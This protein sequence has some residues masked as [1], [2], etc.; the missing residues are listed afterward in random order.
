MSASARFHRP[1]KYAFPAVISLFFLLAIAF[2]GIVRAQPITEGFDGFV[3]PDWTVPAGWTFSGI[4]AWDNYTTPDDF[5]L[6]SPSIKLDKDGNYIR[7]APLVRPDE[8]TFWVKGQGDQVSSA[9]LVEEYCA[10]WS[11]VTQ[12]SPIPTTGT[13]LGP[14]SLQ[15]LAIEV[16]FTYEKFADEGDLAF[17]DV[18][19]TL[20]DPT[21]TPSPTPPPT[22]TPTPTATSTPIPPPTATPPPLTNFY[23]PSFELDPELI[24]WSKVGTASRINRSDEVAYDGD[25]SLVFEE[26]TH[27]NYAARGIETDEDYLVPVIPGKRYNFSGWFYVEENGPGDDIDNVQLLF[28]VIWLN[29]AGDEVST[30]T[31]QG[32]TLEEFDTWTERAKTLIAPPDATQVRI[33]VACR[34]ATTD[35]QNDVYI[36]QF[37]LFIPPATP[38]PTATPVGYKTPSPTPVPQSGPIRGRVYDRVTGEGV[39]GV[40]VLAFFID[41]GLRTSGDVTD[42]SG[43]YSI[44]GIDGAPL[45][46]GHYQVWAQGSQGWGIRSYHDQWYNQK[47]SRPQADVV[48]SNSLGIDFPLY[49]VGEFPMVRVESGDY[50]GDGASDIAVF[51]PTSGL[52]AVRGVTRAYFGSGG[53]IPVSGDYTGDGTSDIA[54]FR[55]ASGL[56]AVRGVTRAYFGTAGDIP[57]PGDY[58]GDGSTDIAVFRSATGLW[59]VKDVS[60]FYFGGWGDAPV[61]VDYDGLDMIGPAIFRPSSGLWAVREV[62]R[63]YFGNAAFQAVP[64]DYTGSGYDRIGVFRPVTGLW[65]I[66]GL[67]RVYYG[68]AQDLPATR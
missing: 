33:Y 20:A 34:R 24:G 9:L 11:E 35:Y 1:L 13:V 36:D 25:Y 4:A 60:R 55:S 64:A 26:P 16:R 37:I 21:P 8:L 50:S 56:W 30:D 51:R 19:I 29:D 48:S 63:F 53:D 15:F 44:D 6:A 59:A 12:V 32:W 52:W 31:D 66:R 17:D 39:G 3:D 10:G 62:T 43:L 38:T 46:A 14:F 42:A 22:A 47:D 67:T 45:E 27:L 41:E 68:S 7:T 61:P 49:R 65:A 2:P 23:N 40:Y 18:G 57:V 58:S 54:V 28:N 5:G